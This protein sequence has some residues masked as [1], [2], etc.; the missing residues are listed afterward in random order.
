MLRTS[1]RRRQRGVSLVEALVSFG[2]MAFGMLAVVG[3]QATLRGSGDLARQRAEAVRIGQD[4]IEAWRGFTTLASTTGR[5]AF[6][7]ITTQDD[8]TVTPANANATYVL[9]RTVSTEAAVNGTVS[10]AR[11]QLTVDV[12]WEDRSGQTQ[13]VRL[14]SSIAGVEPELAASVVLGAAPEPALQPRGRHRAVPPSAVPVGI[15]RSAYLPP[16]Q[17]QSSDGR[18]AWVFNNTTGL[19]QFCTTSATSTAS[20][21][22]TTVAISGN[23]Q[24]TGGNALLV[25][26]TVRFATS[27]NPANSPASVANPTGP[28]FDNF[29]IRIE[30]ASGTTNPPERVR[31]FLQPLVDNQVQYEC[32]VPITAEVNSWNGSISFSNLDLANDVRDDRADEYKVCRYHELASYSNVSAALLNQNFV[33]IRAGDGDT[34]YQCPTTSTPRTWAHQPAN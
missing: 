11:R 32:A 34:A 28:G 25:S 13:Q 29:R 5:T 7:D 3:M 10:P 20:I 33:I 1:S 17:S 14:V 26:G 8:Q 27:G 2:V 31:C 12:S 6:A 23:T 9:R 16:G 21:V 15:G 19:L 22:L 24:C 30:P 18:V 4:A